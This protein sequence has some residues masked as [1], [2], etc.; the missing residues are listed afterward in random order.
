MEPTLR[1][2]EALRLSSSETLRHWE[3]AEC[4]RVFAAGRASHVRNGL[5]YKD[6][7]GIFVP[8]SEGGVW[9]VV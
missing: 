9:R 1:A 5:A 3:S 8:P 6:E 7:A 4:A 2:W